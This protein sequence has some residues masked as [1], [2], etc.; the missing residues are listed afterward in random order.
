MVEVERR[1]PASAA[2]NALCAHV[3][4]QSLP[5]RNQ[6]ARYLHLVTTRSPPQILSSNLFSK[7][8]PQAHIPLT[9]LLP[10]TTST[11]LNPT[12]LP[13]REQCRIS[14][15]P[16][17][18]PSPCATPCPRTRP[19]FPNRPQHPP[20]PKDTS[21]FPPL[22][23][24]CPLNSRFPHH[25]LA[26]HTPQVPLPL[27]LGL[28]RG[29]SHTCLHTLG[30]LAA[31]VGCLS[32]REGM[33][34]IISRRAGWDKEQGEEGIWDREGS[35]DSSRILGRGGLIILRRSWGC[36]LGRVRLRRGRIMCR[37]T[38][39]HSLSYSSCLPSCSPLST[40]LYL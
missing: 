37:R 19:I 18:R 21:A 34:R 15:H 30:L 17:R 9:T 4:L 13:T 12:H 39:V 38:C 7:D 20:R 29:T 3:G 27:A 28:R 31:R 6:H 32:S 10:P 33:G 22:P 8:P 16:P 2:I 1:K 5:R 26:H 25:T 24:P 40:F 23:G 11:N 36:S 35:R 14:T